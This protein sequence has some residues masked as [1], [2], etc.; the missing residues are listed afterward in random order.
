MIKTD[1]QDKFNEFKSNTRF[2]STD[3]MED[4]FISGNK[5]ISEEEENLSEFTE[6]KNFELHHFYLNSQNSDERFEVNWTKGINESD[7]SDH[8]KKN[9]IYKFKK[10]MIKNPF[11]RT[12][13]QK[14][15]I[16]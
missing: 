7:C 12:Y 8:I 10:T 3:L 16:N 5:I 1:S 14:L 9:K 2:H 11:K 6:R 13:N 4:S 15:N